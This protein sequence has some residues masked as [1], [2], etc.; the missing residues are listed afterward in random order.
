VPIVYF[1]ASQQHSRFVLRGPGNSIPVE[2]NKCARCHLSTTKFFT[3]N[4]LS[5]ARNGKTPSREGL[6]LGHVKHKRRLMLFDWTDVVFEHVPV[7]RLTPVKARAQRPL[8]PSLTQPR[9]LSRAT[10]ST[11]GV[12]RRVIQ[13]FSAIS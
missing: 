3:K 7:V 5:M 12:P 9:A 4:V 8:S 11:G 1:I 10:R 6:E 2:F 13:V